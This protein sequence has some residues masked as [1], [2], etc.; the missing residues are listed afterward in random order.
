MRVSGERV[1]KGKNGESKEEIKEGGG[2]KMEGQR[3][4]E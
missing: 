4:K 3:R 1:G 2:T